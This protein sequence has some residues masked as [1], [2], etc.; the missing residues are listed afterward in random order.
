MKKYLKFR[1]MELSSYMIR[2][3]YISGG[4]LQ[5][6]KNKQKKKKFLVT[7]DILAI[8]TV[9]KHR[10]ISCEAKMQHRDIT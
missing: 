6:L 8:F 2:D 3:S 9:V 5:N 4:N 7:Y 10:E 1:E